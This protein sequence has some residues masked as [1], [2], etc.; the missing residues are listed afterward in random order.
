MKR[1]SFWFVFWGVAIIGAAAAVVVTLYSFNQF[2]RVAA[3]F[4]GTCAP[5][6]GIAG[7]ED[8]QIDPKTRRAYIS[9]FDRRSEDKAARGG[10]FVFSIDDPLADEAWRDRTNGMPEKFA[11]L[12][13]HFYDD[14]S[15]RRLFVVNAATNAV[16]VYDVLDN[17]DL[18][19]VET[20][21]ERRLTSPND[22]VAVGPRSFYVTN[23][24]ESGRDSLLAR[25]Q[26]LLRIGSGRVLYY[27]GIAWR[28]AAE[29]LRFANGINAGREGS[30]IYV[31]ETA[32]Q[33]LRIYDRDAQSG[34]LRLAK[35]AGMGAGLDNINID[36][37][38]AL[39][40][41]AQPKPLQLQ[42]GET[43]ATP[44][45][46]IRYEDIEG[47]SAAPTKI[48]ADDGS[49]ISGSTVADR[50]GSTLLIGARLEKKFL[51]C[52]LPG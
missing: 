12:G 35:V 16:E 10:V 52:N 15:V 6:T 41:G 44:S 24:A 27:D 23:D 49:Q 43:G 46:V 50:L 30:R 8:I 32:A 21:A 1:L 7:P 47:G 33:A 18:A 37:V 19:H 2:D 31:A 22:I 26:F 13:L 38:G 42:T 36:R 51:I 9:S 25:I 48:F 17:G 20:L 4:D 29:G 40:I 28:I 5:V 45:L 3:S 11:P 14:G 39:W 34:A